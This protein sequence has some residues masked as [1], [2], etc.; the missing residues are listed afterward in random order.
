[1]HSPIRTSPAR[2]VISSLSALALAVSLS[3]CLSGGGGS[4]S[5]SGSP[6]DNPLRVST[7]QGD[8]TGISESGMRV[9][10]GIRYGQAERFASPSFPAA[11]DGVIELD[12]SFG[13]ACPQIGSNFGEASVNEDCLFLNVYAPEE[14]GDYPVMVWIHGGAFIYGSGGAS[15]EPERLV[16]QG[17][18][19]V[20]LNYRLG[21]LGFL[22]L[23]ALGDPNFGLQDQ[24]LALQWVQDNIAEFG[25]DPDNVT[26]FGESAGG[27]SVMSQLAS[28]AAAGLFH[29]AIVQSG[30]YNGDQLP[31]PIGQALFGN[32]TVAATTCAGSADNEAL[33]SCLRSLSVE[34]LLDAQAGSALPSTGTPTLPLSIN[35]ALASGEF[36]Q[37]PVIMGSNL[38]EGSLFTLLALAEDPTAFASAEAYRDAVADLLS[39]DPSLNASDIANHYLGRFAGDPAITV[40][41]YS[42]IGTDWRFNCPNSA[43]WDLLRDQVPTWGYWFTDED[44][45][46]LPGLP[47][48][49]EMGATHT[50]E[51]QFV[52]AS[53]ETLRAR[54][55]TEEQLQLAEHM[56]RYWTNFAR[57]G[58]DPAIGPNGTDGAAEAVEW[59][60]LAASDQIIELDSPRPGVVAKA[61]FDDTHNCSYWRDQLNPR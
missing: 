16:E 13:S 10:R 27:H 36:N 52:L 48:V 56:A 34:E 7:Q 22:P 50:A 23:A 42:A 12:E 26:L 2:L 8:Y 44:A 1:M 32:P 28:P 3:G 6:A 17:V 61:S 18:V 20:T 41:A 30:S 51:I 60:R 40:T 24:Q 49:I 53:E 15:Y 5:D 14:P 58:D 37:V 33:V 54:G 25:G 29:K 9:F 46:L 45:P 57:Y 19:V 47:P 35:D 4:S 43:Q 38:N 39:E 59:P 31:L 11:H 21:A 55:A